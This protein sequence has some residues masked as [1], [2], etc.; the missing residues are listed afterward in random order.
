M[1]L[2][3]GS[4]PGVQVNV[5]GG[6]VGDITLGSEYYAVAF[7][8]GD[9]SSG[10]AN[11]NSPTQITSTNELEST[12]GADTP[13]VGLI[14]ELIFNGANSA[15][16]YVYGVMPETIAV[17]GE[18][19][20]GTQSFTLGNSPIIEDAAEV[21]V[22]DTVN[23]IDLDVE[24][25]YAESL[26]TPTTDDT[27]FVNPY[28]GDV[29][30]DSSTD[31]EVSYKYAD[32]SSAFDAADKVVGEG[33]KGV[34]AVGSAAESVA[35][36]VFGKV[37]SLRDP[38]YRMILPFVGATPNANTSETP[39]D[40][41][42]DANSYSDN[43]SSV[44]GF[45]VV[46]ARQNDSTRTTIGAAA[47]LAAGN[48]RDDPILTDSLSDIT[49]ETGKDD[50]AI[51]T[52][53]ERNKLEDNN[54]VVLK[55]GDGITVD[56]TPSTDED[57]VWNTTFQSVR[58]VD[59][60]VLGT[61]EVLKAYRGRLDIDSPDFDTE[62]IAAQTVLDFLEDLRDERILQPNTEDE[63]NRLFARPADAGSGKIGVEIG[64]TPVY[65]V[66]TSTATI[67]VNA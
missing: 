14:R 50:E 38:D 52:K 62:A 67:T 56:R 30:T 37:D 31:Y 54:L 39:P 58:T 59:Q 26:S 42:Y 46:P 27:A 20:T 48:A 36:T 64:V 32:W 7:A 4:I 47:G 41:M 55:A 35:S 15:G 21:T 40:P 6:R 29:E 19:A 57:E 49:V 44:P 12:F 63:P 65:A 60:A 43:L 5:E 18:T 16:G 22:T 66:E 17:T 25:R 28:T 11:V 45:A 10:S 3:F 24:F 34:W 1:V 23:S 8:L 51:F 13:I 53:S 2:Q 61:R 33:E 9:A